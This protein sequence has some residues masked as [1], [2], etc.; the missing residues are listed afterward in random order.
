MDQNQPNQG[1]GH[2][3]GPSLLPAEESEVSFAVGE[4]S[5][6]ETAQSS[7]TILPGAQGRAVSLHDNPATSTGAAGAKNRRGPEGGERFRCAAGAVVVAGARRR[8]GPVH[9]VSA[10]VEDW[11]VSTEDPHGGFSPA[12]LESAGTYCLGTLGQ[13]RSLPRAFLQESA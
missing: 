4:G 12:G 7:V 3:G 8:P 6:V 13:G 2:E 10:V 5:S 1:T 11:G 9:P